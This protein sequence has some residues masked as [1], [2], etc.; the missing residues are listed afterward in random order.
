MISFHFHVQGFFPE[1]ER[2]I[3]SSNH[4]D[5]CLVENLMFNFSI[6]NLFHKIGKCLMIVFES[7]EKY[8]VS[9]AGP[10]VFQKVCAT[11]MSTSSVPYVKPTLAAGANAEADP[12]RAAMERAVILTIF[13]M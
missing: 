1:R 7:I 3:T 5:P 4:N 11:E 8:P 13:R 10:S 6:M 9:T 12:A 2:E